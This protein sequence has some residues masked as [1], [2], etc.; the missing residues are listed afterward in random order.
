MRT[1]HRLRAACC[2][3][4]L[5]ATVPLAAA[6][7]ASD[8]LKQSAD[9]L[10]EAGTLRATLTIHGEGAEMFKSAMPVGEVTLLIRRE[11]GNQED[12]T[13]PGWT[14]RITGS[15]TTGNNKDKEPVK[16]DIVNTGD[17]LR[18]IDHEQKKLF[19]A[20][21]DRAIATRSPGY[22]A[23]RSLIL[24]EILTPAPY[25]G[26][27]EAEATTLLEPAEVNGVA[28]DVVEVTYPQNTAR[29]A[30]AATHHVARI[31]IGKE[32]HL[33]RRIER[34]SGSDA[35]TMSIVLELTDL[36]PGADITDKDFEMPLPEGY[37][38][39]EAMT[40]RVVNP[41]HV[42]ATRPADGVPTA[43][44]PQNR[45][46]EPAERFSPAPDFKTTLASGEQ[47][48]LETLRGSVAVLYFW[49]T[50]SMECRP[51]GPLV[52]TLADDYRDRGVRVVGMAV[53][54]RDP[55][56]AVDAARAHDFTFEV[57]P[58]A[59]DTTEP[60]NVVVFPT[61]VVIGTTGDLIGTVR[62]RRGDEPAALVTQ[63]RTLVDKAL[64]QHK[65]PESDPKP[66]EPQPADK[67]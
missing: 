45:P 59:T 27:L 53:R 54:E 2:A 34:V 6:Q 37:E 11:P 21:P 28:C 29:S 64:D 60:F 50:W 18:W 16:V 65:P 3:A 8:I 10:V 63:V 62:L 25:A 12:G 40:T 66:D 13:P 23:A 47:L 31:A 38:K 4:A 26:E 57:A 46:E 30:R 17:T 48:S 7:V 32:D 9:A 35:F 39:A 42:T 24:S 49:G 20:A 36:K 67:P 52:S 44:A 56:I 15:T 5:L 14:S 51:Y 22:A 33:P 19:E 1:I 43:T 55:K 61:F 58:A 41:G